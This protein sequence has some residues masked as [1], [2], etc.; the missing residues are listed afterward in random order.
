MQKQLQHKRAICSVCGLETG[1]FYKQVNG[2][3][4]FKCKKCKLL[5]V[6]GITHQEIVSFYDSSDYF[7][8]DSKIG[9]NN[10]LADE[11]NHR[12]NAREIIN[13]VSKIRDMKGLRIL[14]IGCAFGF[15]L[16]EAKKATQGNV[17]DYGIEI[18]SYAYEYA[19]NHLGLNVYNCEL[20]RCNFEPLF[21]DVIFLIGTIEHL[22]SPMAT[23]GNISKLL[24]YGGLL[25][26][27]TLDTGG[28]MPLYSLKPPE[29]LFYFNHDNL[30]ALV[31]N[32]GC[33]ILQ[34]KTYFGHYQLNDLFYRL[35]EF[36][37]FSLFG[38]ISNVLRK[39][40]PRLSLKI[41]T[42]EMILIAKKVR[43]NQ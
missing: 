7:N 24:K 3:N 41:P 26:I 37:S 33:E 12:K 34:S 14:D 39:Y 28:I 21:F 23:L 8:N 36:L 38:F 20:D 29:H 6:E 1:C 11:K 9:Y 43:V 10:Y 40:F 35:G 4:L 42:N 19:K 16:D 31:K 30:S 25:V 15:L 2:F 22:I 13:T 32:Y 27:T 18:S 5:W 17:E